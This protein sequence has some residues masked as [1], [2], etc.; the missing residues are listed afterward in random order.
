[1]DALDAGVGQDGLGDGGAVAFRD[2]AVQQMVGVAGKVQQASA[3][4]SRLDDVLHYQ[5]DWRFSRAAD[6]PPEA[7]AALGDDDRALKQ[8]TDPFRP[9]HRV[10]Q[11]R[12]IGAATQ[13]QSSH[14]EHQTVVFRF[15]MTQLIKMLNRN[16]KK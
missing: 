16:L 1:M 12:C 13:H 7:R 4:L 14:Q 6:A 10:V 9:H 8:A 3:D 5:R 2:G 15:H 11:A